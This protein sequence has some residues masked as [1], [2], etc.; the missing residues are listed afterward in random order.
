MDLTTARRHKPSTA[1]RVFHRSEHRRH[2][3]EASGKKKPRSWRDDE[4]P[5]RSW[6]KCPR[7]LGAELRALRY[8]LARI[9]KYGAK[10]KESGVVGEAEIYLSRE[11]GEEM[12]PGQLEYDEIMEPEAGGGRQ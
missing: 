12:A 5:P 6:A 2:T 4:C 9:R 7:H 8:L 11:T 1:G 10:M 3:A